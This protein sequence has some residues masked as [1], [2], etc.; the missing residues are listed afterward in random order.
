VS[1]ALLAAAVLATLL[2]GAGL[3]RAD[4]AEGKR[5]WKAGQEL[6]Q[7]K[8]FLEAAREFEAGYAVAPRPLFLMNIGHAYRRANELARAKQAYEALLRLQPDLPQRNEVEEYIKSINDALLA[9]DTSSPDPFTRGTPPPSPGPSPPRSVE[10]AT[11][12]PAPPAITRLPEEPVI[13]PYVEARE[14]AP[15]PEVS[16]FRK[17]WFWV[18]TGAIVAGGVAVAIIASRPS[19]PCPGTLCIRE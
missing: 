1:R 13:P 18:V 16:M 9:S 8:R 11:P 7:Q 2:A 6:Y 14:T 10:S 12:R 15:E 3:A 4:E 5:H 17:P 19:S